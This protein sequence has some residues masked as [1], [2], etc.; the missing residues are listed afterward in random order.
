MTFPVRRWV[1]ERSLGWL[2]KRRNIRIHWCKKP[3][4][5]MAFLKLTCADI[6]L[7]LIFG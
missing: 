3:E 7:N 4:I 6:L 5:W 1:V 2:G